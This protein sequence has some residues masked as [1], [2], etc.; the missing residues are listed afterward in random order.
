MIKIV[1]RPYCGYEGNFK[2]FKKWHF[3]FYDVNMM[4]CPRCSGVLNYYSGLRPGG[5]K[6]ELV[7]RIR[8]KPEMIRR[9]SATKH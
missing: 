1:K 8:P 6:S 9:K 2:I 5:E 3:R 4:Q 7:I